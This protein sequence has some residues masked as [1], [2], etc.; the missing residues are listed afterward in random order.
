MRLLVVVCVA[1]L[2]GAFVWTVWAAFAGPCHNL[3]VDPRIGSWCLPAS[4]V[5]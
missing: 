5:L 3:V 4:G 2:V 1:L